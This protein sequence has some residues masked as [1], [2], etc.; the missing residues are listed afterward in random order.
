[1]SAVANFVSKYTESKSAPVLLRA[2]ALC[3][4]FGGQVVLNK[5]DVEMR[6]GEVVLLRGENGSGKTTLLNILTGNLDPDAGEIHYLA[7]SNPRVYRFPRSWWQELNPFGHFTPEFVAR[8]SIGR[9]WQDVRLFGSQSLRDNLAVATPGHSGENPLL[10]LFAPNR[11]AERESEINQAADTMLARL[12][13][14]GREDSSA[15]KISLG[16]S[17]RVAIARAVLAGAK[18]LFLDEP[19]AGLDRQGIDDVLALLQ[20]LVS[21]Q[22]VT[23]VIVEHLFNQ[24]YLQG[25]VTT[26]WLLENGVITVSVSKPH[27]HI[28][29]SGDDRPAWFSLLAGENTEIIDEQLPRG[30]MLT[31]IRRPGFFLKQA[32]PVLEVKNLVVKREHRVV[33]GFDGQGNHTGLSFTLYEGER[34]VLQAPNGWGKSTFLYAASGL[35]PVHQGVIKLFGIQIENLP[36]WERLSAG[37]SVLQSDNTGFKNLTVSESINLAYKFNHII[38][39]LSFDFSLQRKISS[40]SGGERQILMLATLPKANFMMYDEPFIAL[41]KNNFIK[42]YSNLPINTESTELILLPTQF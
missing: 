37:M 41:D 6:Q 7:D 39:P 32:E 21:E 5:V 26:D 20:S 24:T 27:V 36:P 17:K 30:A 25:L 8:K 29:S 22:R 15:D 34:V 40:L 3:K 18:I 31:R 9:T 19:L 23:L 33:V 13:L 14:A 10:A 35:L 4:A 16:Q 38:I 12:G 28:S 1:M 42:Y 11:V 2:E